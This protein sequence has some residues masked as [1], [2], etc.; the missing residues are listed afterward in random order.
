[1]GTEIAPGG[2]RRRQQFLGDLSS[3]TRETLYLDKSWIR[4]GPTAIEPVDE[5]VENAFIV[6]RQIHDAN[7][8][9]LEVGVEGFGEVLSP[10]TE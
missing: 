9:L 2:K 5:S 7:L 3:S 4:R 10:V 6:V 8:C 1:L